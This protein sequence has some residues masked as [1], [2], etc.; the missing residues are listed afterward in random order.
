MQEHLKDKVFGKRDW[1]EWFKE[2]K[3][4][5]RL[6]IGL[7]MMICLALFLHFREVR[8]EMLEPGTIAKNYVV[9]QVDFEFFDQDSTLVLRQ[10]ALKDIGSIY[11]IDEKELK[12]RR[13]N[14]ENFL[15]HHHQWRDQAQE[16]TFE[17]MNRIADAVEDVLVVAR[18]TD[19]RTLKK[20]GELHLDV[21]DYFVVPAHKG[22]SAILPAEFWQQVSKE[23][24]EEDVPAHSVQFV[25]NYFQKFQWTLDNDLVSQ[26]TLKEIVEES[27]PEKVRKIRSGSRIIG[28]GERV[29]AKH[30]SMLQAMKSALGEGRKLWQPLTIMGSL[31][32][33]LLIVLLGTYYFKFNHKDILKSL[34]KLSLY[35]TI[36]IVTLIFSK[37]GEF[38]LLK[39][40]SSVTEWIRY[41]LFVPFAAILLTVLLGSEVA[42]FTTCFLSVLLGI[43][44]AVD[45]S[46]FLVINLILG[47]VAIIFSRALRKRKEVFIVCL[48]VW[49]SGIPILFSYSF[50]KNNFWS[51]TLIGDFVSTLCFMLLTAILVIGFLPLLESLFHVMTDITLMEYMDPNNELLRRLSVEAPGT[52][53]HSLVVGT[54][55]EAAAQAIGANGLFCR[56]S[57]QYHDI[58]KLFNPHYFTENQMGGFNI[59]Q[60]LTPAES[61]QVIIAHVPEGETLAKKH[62]LPQSFVDII[63]EHHG[64]TLVYYFYCKQVEQEGG[65]V[66]AVDE[67]IFRYPGPKPRSKESAIIMI[68]DS[69]EAASRSLEEVS[70]GSL[71]ELVNQLIDDKNEEGQFDE[72]QLTFEELGLVKKAIVRTL[73]VTRHLRVKYPGRKRV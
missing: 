4:G 51:I 21:S 48:K 3:L 36:V 41:P 22:A 24:L 5:K 70:E 9:A 61:S 62:G 30:I 54:L 69:V 35:V 63:K 12:E 72:C 31:L 6:L 11:Q 59:H 49:L 43:S 10:E 28:Q 56:V 46:R 1:G 44:L 19:L 34:N 47:V 23:V 68:A 20:M 60:L 13:L 71:T 25:V 7:L 42:L 73:S 65:N 17:E 67:K 50:I 26:K 8:I 16:S 15:I 40:S 45:S 38:L 64:T 32:F 14:F 29:T 55:S 37:I 18:F 57:T 39:N 2:G 53:Q 33:S 58:G 52:Y 27:V 66:D